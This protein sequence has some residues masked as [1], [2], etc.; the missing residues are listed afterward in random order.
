M[1]NVQKINSQLQLLFVTGIDE[2][3]EE[4]ISRRSYN[5]VKPEAEDDAVIAVAQVLSQLRQD[6]LYE[7]LRN[8]QSLLLDN[9]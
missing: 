2:H 8:D 5:N 9:E 4:V 7:A 6:P 3:G 1:E